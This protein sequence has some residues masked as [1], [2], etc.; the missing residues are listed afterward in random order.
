MR[1]GEEQQLPIT[2]VGTVVDGYKRG[3]AMGHPS[4]NIDLLVD[5]ELP[6]HGVY[7]ATVTIENDEYAGQTFNASCHI[8]RPLT[9]GLD[10]ITIEIYILDFDTSI[11][12]EVVEFTLHKYIR[13]IRKFE[14][15]E[16]L[17]DQ[18]TNDKKEIRTFLATLEQV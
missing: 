2:L 6:V 12:D 4:A 15:P 10:Q 14:S 18:I 5:H 7:A 9:F 8:G 11:Y 3:R 17:A 1:Q 16:A 13:P